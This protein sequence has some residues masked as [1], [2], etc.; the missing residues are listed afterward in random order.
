MWP[1]SSRHT[2]RD[3]GPA[4][5][6]HTILVEAQRKKKEAASWESK[7]WRR[8][9]GEWRVESGGEKRGLCWQNNGLGL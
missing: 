5:A 3:A 4:A 2:L 8:G 9:L 6:P 7:D 1:M